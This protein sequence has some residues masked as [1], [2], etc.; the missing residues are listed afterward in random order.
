[1]GVCNEGR[2][3]RDS[4]PP[5]IRIQNPDSNLESNPHINQD[6]EKRYH[7]SYNESQLH[8]KI[9]NL[10]SMNEND[11]QESFFKEQT[12]DK[13]FEL[14]K[15]EEKKI[16]INSFNSEK[17][18]FINDIQNNLNS[19]HVVNVQRKNFNNNLNP[20][21]MNMP[22]PNVQIGLNYSMDNYNVNELNSND[23]E[24][25][26]PSININPNPTINPNMKMKISSKII[27]DFTE[28]TS[29]LI[30]IENGEQIYKHK[31]IREIMKIND[32]K[33]SF[34]IDFLTI[35]LVGQ[36]GVGKSTLI[37]NFLKIKGKKAAQTGTG[38]YVTTE[39]KCYMSNEIPYLRL[40]DTRGIELNV[41]Y[42]AEAVKND[43]SKFIIEQLNTNNINNF[44]SCIW[45]CVTGDRFQQVEE[46]LLN[47]LR[48]SYGENTIPIIIVY[49]QAVDEII[50]SGMTEYI[51]KRKINATFVK[52][53]AERKKLVNQTFLEAYG[54][55]DLLNE[56][57]IKCKKAIQGDM[58][59]VMSNKISEHIKNV[60]IQENA[61]IKRFINEATI[62]NLINE[63]YIVKTHEDFES[64]IINIYGNNIK[65]FFEK[66]KDIINERNFPIFKNS[67]IFINNYDIY[68]SYFIERTENYITGVNEYLSIQ[69]LDLQAK[70]E[71]NHNNN[72]FVVNIRDLNDFR[73]TTS[74]FLQDNFYFIAQK[75]YLGYMVKNITNNLSTSFENSLND[76]IINVIQQ[77]DIVD[78][79]NKCF[80]NKFADFEARINA[81]NPDS[82]NYYKPFPNGGNNYP[83]DLKNY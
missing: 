77:K 73:K 36:S 83:K 63:K 19:F 45:Y 60:L 38:N 39:I 41:N 4:N 79:I 43:A 70:T 72:L 68:K 53:L 75:Y 46:D 42:G 16:L 29:N 66:E 69:L 12:K 15:K 74:N 3:K 55:D 9:N 2:N 58:R 11:I 48:S 25:E 37:N 10:V 80:I 22:A 34:R 52:V 31:I 33:D 50:I 47:A 67:Q 62:L 17:N 44:V 21:N 13:I 32:D 81:P 57:L 8:E 1:M 51:K 56:T 40:V 18:S 71:K 24:V 76:L 26:L 78:Q 23:C 65:Y 28:L 30:Q 7:C 49:T 6:F 61:Y 82:K 64:F 35:M 5:P 59:T 27:N 20:M 54:L 14:L